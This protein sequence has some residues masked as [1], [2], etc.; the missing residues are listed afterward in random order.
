MEY[1]RCDDRKVMLNIWI[2][3]RLRE[4]AADL[5]NARN[6]LYRFECS[7]DSAGARFLSVQ[8]RFE[9]IHGRERFGMGTI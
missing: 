2:V 8:L 1:A 4:G 3:E 9:R 6:I 5:R 7:R